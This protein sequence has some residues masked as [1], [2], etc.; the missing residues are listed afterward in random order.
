MMINDRLWRRDFDLAAW[1]ASA[2]SQLSL[3]EIR[4]AARDPAGDREAGTDHEGLR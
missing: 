3:L 1:A 4:I 2:C